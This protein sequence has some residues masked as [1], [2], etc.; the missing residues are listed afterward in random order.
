MVSDM[1]HRLDPDAVAIGRAV[2]AALTEAGFTLA[3][4]APRLGLSLQTLSRRVNGTLPFTW[5]ELMRA[6][7][8]TGV[9]PSELAEAADR[10][11]SRDRAEDA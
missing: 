2:R 3:E 8:I 10:V 9:T 4:A 6:S 11:L 5:P 1:A 7:G